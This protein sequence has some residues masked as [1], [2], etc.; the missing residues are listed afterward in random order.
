MIELKLMSLKCML[1]TMK[2]LE[3]S[4]SDNI[5]KLSSRSKT[6]IPCNPRKPTPLFQKSYHFLK[7]VY[8]FLS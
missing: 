2:I 8:T 4:L 3:H 1:E 7:R 5:V 6:Q